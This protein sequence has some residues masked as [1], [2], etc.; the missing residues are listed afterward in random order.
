MWC[1]C[2]LCWVAEP[3]FEPRTCLAL[4]PKEM[5]I[6]DGERGQE[7]GAKGRSCKLEL[8]SFLPFL[9]ERG[10]FICARDWILQV[11]TPQSQTV[12]DTRNHSEQIPT[13]TIILAMY[14]QSTAEKTW[15]MPTRLEISVS[16]GYVARRLGYNIGKHLW[17]IVR[18][19]RLYGY[20]FAQK[21]VANSTGK[22]TRFVRCWGRIF[23]YLFSK[24]SIMWFI[25]KIIIMK[26]LRKHV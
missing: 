4:I 24:F 19:S 16:K 10:S 7:T 3:G 26:I 23:S 17:P 5:G 14:R 15:K 13:Q 1:L 8:I 20:Y 12:P 18:K 25:F 6:R 11:G 21:Y 2:S 9:S 22:V